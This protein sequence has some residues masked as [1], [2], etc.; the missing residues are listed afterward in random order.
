MP[1]LNAQILTLSIGMTS[2]L[3]SMLTIR[4]SCLD[5]SPCI[6]MPHTAWSYVYSYGDEVLR[7]VNSLFDSLVGVVYLTGGT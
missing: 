5:Q 3:V 4:Y 2:E 6:S 7:H 1:P